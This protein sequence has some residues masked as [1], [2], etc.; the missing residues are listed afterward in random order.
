LI[1]SLLLIR[2]VINISVS[3]KTSL[4]AAES[5]TAVYTPDISANS[6]MAYSHIV[7]KNPFGPPLVFRSLIS[8]QKLVSQSSSHSDL[9]LIGTVTGPDELSY[10]VFKDNSQPSQNKQRVFSFGKEVFNYGTLTRI[11]KDS[12]EITQGGTSFTVPLIKLTKI[13]HSKARSGTSNLKF[14]TKIDDNQYLLDQRRVQRA[15]ANP[16]QIMTDARLLPNI[17]NGQQEGFRIMEVKPGG[18][19]DSLGL[20][21]SDILLRINGL[22]LSGPEAAVQTMSALKGMKKINLDIIRAGSSMSLGYQME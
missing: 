16:Q 21:N 18:I 12:V 17:V 19:Y 20:L 2:D 9:V 11:E 7:E 3:D 10:A 6:I 13:Q 4:A 15:I 22:D 1:T 8:T 5:D 14:V